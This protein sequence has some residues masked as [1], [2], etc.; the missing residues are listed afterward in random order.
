[1]LFAKPNPS[2]VSR[3]ARVSANF[4][5]LSIVL[6]ECTAHWFIMMIRRIHYFD[7][8]LQSGTSSF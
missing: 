7:L 1:V 8:G 5:V 4:E 2:S 6:I 3:F